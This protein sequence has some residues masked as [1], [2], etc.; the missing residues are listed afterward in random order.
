VLVESLRRL[1]IDVDVDAAACTIRVDGCD[2]RIPAASA[3]LF[4]GNSGTTVR[5]L[6]ALVTLGHGTFRL[7]GSQRMRERPIGDLLDARA[8]L[9]ADTRSMYD[10]GCP[11]VIVTANGLNGGTATVRGDISSRSSAVC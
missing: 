4:V 9:G 2:G 11:P 6:T 3:D 5:F 1:E 10:N 8:Q 7:D